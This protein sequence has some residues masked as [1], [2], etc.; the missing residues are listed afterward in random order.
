[1]E[2]CSIQQLTNIRFELL[3]LR[4]IFSAIAFELNQGSEGMA[5]KEANMMP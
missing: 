1:M 4:C 3:D 5:F 2:A